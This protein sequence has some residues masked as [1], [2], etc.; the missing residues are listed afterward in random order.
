MVPTW[1]GKPGKMIEHFP[2]REKPENL[3]QT[4]K[5]RKFYPKC[6]KNEEISASFYFYLFIYFSN[7]GKWKRKIPEGKFV[8][9]KV[10]ELFRL[11]AIK[12]QT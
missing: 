5:V 9:P 1:T 8:S 11:A 12:R 3:E 4:G 2:F 7:T 10:V 6:W